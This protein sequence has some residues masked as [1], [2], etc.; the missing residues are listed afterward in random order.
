MVYEIR[1]SCNSPCVGQTK[2]NLFIGLSEHDPQ[3]PSHRT[4]VTNHLRFHPN[5]ALDF[6][7]PRVLSRADHG[8]KLLIKE[9]LFIQKYWLDLNVDKSSVP[10]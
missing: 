5:H 7:N 3:T 6:N 9:T 1:G 4:D 8:Q 2:R 10:L